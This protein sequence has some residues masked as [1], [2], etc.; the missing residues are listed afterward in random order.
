MKKIMMSRQD[1]EIL[2]KIVEENNV[3]YNFWIV[4]TDASGIGYTLDVEFEKELNGRDAV[5]KIPISGV[6]NW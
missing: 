4:Y 3:D 6:E 1:L 2:N 5:V